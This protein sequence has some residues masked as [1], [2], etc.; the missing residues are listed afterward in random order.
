MNKAPIAYSI[1]EA[2]KLLSIGRTS[3]YAAI[4]R[5]ELKTCKLGR[6]TLMAADDL[7]GWLQSLPRYDGGASKL[8][9]D[10]RGGAR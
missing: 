6:R 5:G 3:L 2:S 10:N 7:H 4:K 1:S 8:P 9:D